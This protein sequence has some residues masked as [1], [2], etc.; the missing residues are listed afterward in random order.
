M[1]LDTGRWWSQT[2][3][4]GDLVLH[5]SVSPSWQW[6]EAN[7]MI[8]VLVWLSLSGGGSDLWRDKALTQAQPHLQNAVSPF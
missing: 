5:T 3:L 4:A 7:L 1:V 2:G 6:V 8:L